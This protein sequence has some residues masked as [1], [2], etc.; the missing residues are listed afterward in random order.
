MFKAITRPCPVQVDG[1]FQRNSAG[2]EP[3]GSSLN[4]KDFNR[5]LGGLMVDLDDVQRM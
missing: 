2:T 4:K 1:G 5:M 3:P